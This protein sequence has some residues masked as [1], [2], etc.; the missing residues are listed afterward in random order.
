MSTPKQ[1]V[2]IL[3]AGTALGVVA[4]A[5]RPR[6]LALGEA[7]EAQAAE[8][9]QACVSSASAARVDTR[10][11]IRLHRENLAAF[12]DVRS[13]DA[14]ASGHVADAFHLPCR[15]EAPAWL[16]RIGRRK[17][18]ILYGADDDVERVAQALTARGTRDVRILDGGF[19][20]WRTADGP[21]EAGFCDACK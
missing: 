3:A 21:A 10:E 12:A 20:A 13:A 17:S 1:I 15:S 11:A 8:S 16:D 7:V 18:V 4:N 14:Y 19:A 2:L 9:P 6:A 5:A